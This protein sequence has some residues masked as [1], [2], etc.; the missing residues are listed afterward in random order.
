[1]CRQKGY[2]AASE[3]RHQPARQPRMGTG[4]SPLD[5]AL[6]ETIERRTGQLRRTPVCDGLEGETFWLVAQHGRRADYV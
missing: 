4:I 5:D 1:V 3:V 6:L 2:R